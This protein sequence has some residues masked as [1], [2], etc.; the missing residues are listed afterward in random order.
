MEEGWVPFRL[1]GLCQDTCQEDV[2]VW[3]QAGQFCAEVI[4]RTQKYSFRGMKNLS[5]KFHQEALTNTFF[6]DFCRKSIKTWKSVPNFYKFQSMPI[7]AIC[8]NG[9][10]QETILMPKNIF[11][12]LDHNYWNSI[13]AKTHFSSSKT[14][15]K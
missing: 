8:S 12:K 3:C 2:A 5:K 1:K 14:Y 7:L 10:R 6:K 13:D 4:T 15:S 11:T 9:P